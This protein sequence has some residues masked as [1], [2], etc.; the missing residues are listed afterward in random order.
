M[1]KPRIC[2][3]CRDERGLYCNW[4]G[5]KYQPWSLEIHTI[6]K[7]RRKAKKDS[8]W[9]RRRWKG[10]KHDLCRGCVRSERRPYLMKMGEPRYLT[11]DDL[12]L[13]SHFSGG[14]GG[15]YQNESR[16]YTNVERAYSGRLDCI[17]APG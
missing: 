2:I 5:T 11:T 14:G 17:S 7:W 15:G 10:K 8:G 4:C 16:L 3:F 1:S 9:E 12:G 6:K 13:P